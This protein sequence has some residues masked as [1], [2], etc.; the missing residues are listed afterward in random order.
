MA[1]A[2]IIY[3]KSKQLKNGEYPVSLRIIHRDYPAVY[4]RVS[5]LSFKKET[6]WNSELSRFTPLKQ[7]YKEHNKTLTNIEDKADT[8][9]SRLLSKDEFTLSKFKSLFCDKQTSDVVL[10]AYIKYLNY[11][12][13]A[14]KY[15]TAE[16]YTASM[17]ALKTF[18]NM[19]SLNFSDIDFRFLLSF[20]HHLRVKGNSD[21]TISYKIRPLRALHY[22]YCYEVDIPQPNA[23]KRFKVGRL[24][25]VSAK[26]SLSKEQFI[27]FTEYIPLNNS[28]KIAKDIF[29]FSFLTRGMNIADISKLKRSNIVGDSI[30]YRRSKTGS[31]FT[32]KITESIRIILENYNQIGYI[33]SILKPYHKDEKYSIRLFTKFVNNNLKRIAD[34]LEI[35]R[36]TTYY[37]RHTYSSLARENGFSVEM[38]SQA[39]GHQDLKTTMVYLDSFADEQ[40]DKMTS[41]IFQSILTSR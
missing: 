8:I 23:Y 41:V 7:G 25:R 5:G 4:Y 31:T 22:K 39:L 37:A 40:M 14:E 19:G 28:E 30:V 21:N 34:E 11:L 1:T 27:N 16:S 24:S 9:I 13:Q 15:G 32:I 6:E 12:K 38:I 36:I 17:N 26:R 18:T 10:D 2:K 33:F 20:E 29:M 35:P 3:R